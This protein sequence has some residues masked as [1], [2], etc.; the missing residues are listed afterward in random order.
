[1]CEP[2]YKTR[3]EPE[4]DHCDEFIVAAMELNVKTEP[5]VS[6]REK[7]SLQWMTDNYQI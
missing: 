7:L 4:R 5:C 6:I 1:M 3:R 2:E